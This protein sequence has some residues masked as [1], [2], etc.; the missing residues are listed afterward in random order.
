M[1]T[2]F[3]IGGITIHRLIEQEH[4][5]HKALTLLPNLTPAL[6]D[7]NRHWLQ[8][9]VM[10]AEDG[11]I[12]CFQSYVVCTPH[13]KILI[14]S[15][16]GNDKNRPRNPD[17][18]MKTDDCYMTALAAAGLGVE[19]ID[20]VMCSHMH[21]DHIGWNTRLIDGRWVP[22]FPNAKYVFAREEYDYWT[23]MHRTAAIPAFADSILPIIEAGR[24]E[25]V[26]CDHAIGDH[27]RL[28]PT[29]GHTPGHVAVCLGRG[30]DDGVFPGDLIHSPL[31]AR[32]PHLTVPFD[33]DKDLA[34]KTRRAFLERY[35]DTD[36]VWFTTHFPS[37]SI[38][39]VRSWDEGFRF[40][41]IME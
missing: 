36:T 41:P 18:H 5:R 26:R 20:Y 32:Y 38:G 31:Q 3:E 6:L 30:G 37:P 13:H 16:I 39:H 35:A 19:D 11:L 22:T 12:L 1:T 14:D 9:S 33:S 34:V 15:C 17:W 27:L 28:L 29:S 23:E 24:A 8:P 2:R 10:D 21:G 40:L 4:S 25:L 7:E